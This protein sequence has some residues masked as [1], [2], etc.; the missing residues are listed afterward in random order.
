MPSKN[1]R[2]KVSFK[3]TATDDKNRHYRFNIEFYVFT[4]NGQYIAYCP[5]LDLSTSGASFNEAVSAFYECFQ[6]YVE[7]CADSDTLISDLRAHGWKLTRKYLQAPGFS[8]LMKKAE[9]KK[10][11]NSGIGFEKIVAPTQITIA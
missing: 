3:T 10:L 11:F 9:M 4:E 8:T 7:S 2:T 1:N 6:L 5:A